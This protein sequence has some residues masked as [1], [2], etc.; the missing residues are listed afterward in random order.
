MGGSL[1]QGFPAETRDLAR[2]F[3]EDVVPLEPMLVRFLNRNWR[4]RDEIPDLL[5]E[6]YVRVYEA[7]ADEQPRAVKPFLFAIARNLMID[8]LRQMNVVSFE[9]VA[10]FDKLNVID[11]MP[12]PERSVSAREEL[13]QLQKAL[14]ALPPRCRQ[15][16]IWR[17]IEG[18]SQREVARKL[19]VTEE[20]VE[21]QVAKAMRL[22]ANSIHGHRGQMVATAKRYFALRSRERP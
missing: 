5:Q 7:A 15:I 3:V 14:D 10:D 21:S 6:V 11:D 2:W 16:V 8:R 19:G 1:L 12:S 9:T 18:M 13:R 17:K 22:L 4:N 20:V